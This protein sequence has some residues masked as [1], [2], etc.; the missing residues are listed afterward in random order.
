VSCVDSGTIV[1]AAV[2]KNI[3]DAKLEGADGRKNMGEV[4][5]LRWP[6]RRLKSYDKWFT[7]S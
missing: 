4:K 2:F 6:A 7:S 5:P 1:V 3:E